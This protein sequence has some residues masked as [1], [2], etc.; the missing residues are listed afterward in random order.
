[1]TLKFV[2]LPGQKENAPLVILRP[3]NENELKM[4]RDT[5]PAKLDDAMTALA[6]KQAR[7]DRMQKLAVAGKDLLAVAYWGGTFRIVDAAGKIRA[8]NRLDQDITA[9]F[10]MESRLIVGLADGRLMAF[11]L[12]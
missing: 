12:K 4:I 9:M 3:A 1:M 6:K 5:T 11:E 7:P 8:E 2:S 10:W